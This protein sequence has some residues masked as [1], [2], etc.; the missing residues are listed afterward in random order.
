RLVPVASPEAGLDGADVVVTATGS[1]EPGF[2]GALVRPGMHL[3][4]VGSNSLLKREIDG[5]ELRRADILVVDSRDARPLGGRDLLPALERGI[6]FPEAIRELAPIVAGA[7]VG[8]TDD[9]QITLFK[10]HGLAIEDV[11]VA[12]RVY[13]AARAAGVGREVGV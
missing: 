11:A 6:L 8:R 7:A 10:S 13:Q 5:E 12:A 2:N 4:V 1:R 9:S 3:N